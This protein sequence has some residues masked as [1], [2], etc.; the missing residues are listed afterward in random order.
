MTDALFEADIE[1]CRV[2]GEELTELIV[3]KRKRYGRN[4]RYIALFLEILFP[5]GVPVT[6]YQHMGVIVRILDKIVR[7]ANNMR[8]L[9]AGDESDDTESPL[10]D[11]AG[12][13]AA[14]TVDDRLAVAEWLVNRGDQ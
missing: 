7:W 3:E 11:V 5:E 12:Y 14:A 10:W 9:A 13:G 8:R 6:A 1:M 2:V 4:L